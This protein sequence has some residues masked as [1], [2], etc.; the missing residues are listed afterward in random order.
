M[1]AA[2]F[3]YKMLYNE[4]I[5]ESLTNYFQK[6]TAGIEANDEKAAK[7]EDYVKIINKYVRIYEDE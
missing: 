6:K 4:R 7:F 3:F 2:S 5:I 1:N